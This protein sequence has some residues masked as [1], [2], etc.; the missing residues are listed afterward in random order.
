MAGPDIHLR[1]GTYSTSIANPI[2]DECIRAKYFDKIAAPPGYRQPA[3]LTLSLRCRAQQPVLSGQIFTR[4]KSNRMR[5]PAPLHE[6]LPYVY[7]VGGMLFVS[8][9]IYIGSAIAMSALY[10]SPGVASIL[11]GVM[12]LIKR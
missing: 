4:E 12:V 6:S 9:G 10:M 1:T 2:S 8:G 7:V 11:S 5:L 3:Y